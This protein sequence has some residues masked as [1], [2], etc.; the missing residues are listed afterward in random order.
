MRHKPQHLLR[1]LTRRRVLQGTLGSVAGL[2]AWQQGWRRLNTAAAQHR[3][4]LG[5]SGEE[6]PAWRQ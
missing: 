2:A 6:K 5:R 3:E 1:P 4:P